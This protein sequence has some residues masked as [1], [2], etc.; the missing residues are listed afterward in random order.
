MNFE[1]AKSRWSELVDII[2]YHNKRYYDEDA[3]E[4]TDF[5]YDALMREFG[6]IIGDLNKR[7]GRIMGMS[8]STRKGYT[9]I[10]AEIPSAEM[11]VY[12][13]QLRAMTQG[14]G[15]YTFEFLRYEEAPANIVQKVVEEAKKNASEE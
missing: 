15:T 14:R 1:E 7:R 5:E 2:R 10:E 13:V 12:A 3:P 9:V 6:D 4:I 8:E 11:T